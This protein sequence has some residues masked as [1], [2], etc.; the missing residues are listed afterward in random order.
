MIKFIGNKSFINGSIYED[1]TIEELIDWCKD[2][3]LIAVDTETQG[4]DCHSKKII[5][6]QIGDFNTQWVIDTR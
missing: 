2:K 5:C 1:S 3:D 6:L 4:L